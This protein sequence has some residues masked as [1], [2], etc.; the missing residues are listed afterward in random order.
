[1]L[2]VVDES[3]L[4]EKKQSKENKIIGKMKYLMIKKICCKSSHLMRIN[5]ISK[6]QHLEK[7]LQ[8]TYHLPIASSLKTESLKSLLTKVSCFSRLGS[9]FSTLILEDIL[10]HLRLTTR[11]PSHILTLTLLCLKLSQQALSLLVQQKLNQKHQ[12]TLQTLVFQD[13]CKMLS[14]DST[15]LVRT[16]SQ[17]A[18]L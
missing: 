8:Q 16:E 4:I 18:S 14:L 13:L 6:T 17:S 10:L 7:R 11:G 15:S 3:L 2:Q 9:L 1:M 5:F 12:E